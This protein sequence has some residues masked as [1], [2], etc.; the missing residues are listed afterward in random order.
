MSAVR[1]WHHDGMD[2][3]RDELRRDGQAYGR[4]K[5]AADRTR[6]KLGETIQRAA[7]EGVG[8]AEITRLIGHNLTERTVI[9]IT[10]G[11]A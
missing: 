3:V 4:A 2:D 9:R 5:R 1:T 8:P 7:D 10:K 11:E 6:E